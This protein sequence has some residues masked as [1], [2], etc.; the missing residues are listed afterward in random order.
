[1]PNFF[2]T[3]LV[4]GYAESSI[5]DVGGISEN[6]MFEIDFVEPLR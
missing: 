6:Q 1:M 5:S 3:K 2:L 4:I